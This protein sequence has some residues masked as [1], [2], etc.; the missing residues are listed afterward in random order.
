MLDKLRRHR[1]S[2]A[3]KILLG[4]LALS[5]II[6]FGVLPS[7]SKD[8][9]ANGAIVAKVEGKPI[10]RAELDRV[11]RNMTKR[12][13]E[14]Y[15][16][17]IDDKMLASLNL[18]NVALQTLINRQVLLAEAAK[19]GLRVTDDDLRAQLMAIDAFKN[20]MGQFDPKMYERAIRGAGEGL[21]P[22]KFEADTRDS[23]LIERMQALVNNSVVLTDDQLRE[24]YVAER[25]KAKLAYV[26]VGAESVAAQVKVKPEDVQAYFDVHKAEYALPET[27]KF[28]FVELSPATLSLAQ[29]IDDKELQ[30]AYEK[31]KE[32]FKQDE[33]VRASHILFKVEGE[34]AAKWA[35]AEKKAAEA[36]KKA[37]GGADFAE[38]AKKLSE[39]SSAPNGGDLGTFGR[40]QMV[41][42]FEEVAFGLK[43]GEVSEPVKT[44]FGWHVIKL[45]EHKPAGY[46]SFDEARAELER[47]LRTEKAA[48]QLATVE[49]DVTKELAAGDTLDAVA[50]KH[51]LPVQTTDFVAK[52]GRFPGVLD[53]KPVLDAGFALSQGQT[54]KL[55]D[56][57]VAKY[58]VALDAVN[59]PKEQGL[60]EVRA[61]VEQAVKLER[62]AGLA[63]AKAAELLEAAKKAGSL[64]KAAGK[65]E[66]KETPE[67][68]QIDGE[69]PGFGRDADVFRT[70]YQLR[71]ERP[72]PDRTFNVGGKYYVIQLI[73]RQHADL[74]KFDAERETFARERLQKKQEAVFSD[75]LQAARGRTKVE[76]ILKTEAPMAQSMPLPD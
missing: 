54:S 22:A 55:I 34:D 7:L 28:K 8:Q 49:A 42:A 41:K 6:G 69:V 4:A 59:A 9:S 73:D 52:D 66:V 19:A 33:Q 1:D 37:K 39:D 14:Q 12:Y 51:G 75:W 57:Q 44:Q 48:A 11:V 71:L 36:A 47:S 40:G 15:G 35:A 10:Y 60:D 25:E 23:L 58:I 5:F 61:Q 43:P 21:T 2:Y 29:K 16:A 30:A 74:A 63:G 76:Q 65:L 68:A 45:V 31:R 62:A 50:A 38:L 67:F 20:E 17:Q 24:L 32:E 70:V 64:K 3:A 13:K 27:R 26:A 72:F 56:A 53:A 18:D 46:R